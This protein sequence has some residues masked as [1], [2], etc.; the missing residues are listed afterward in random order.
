REHD[1]SRLRELREAGWRAVAAL[2]DLFGD[3]L[4]G[5]ED[6][7]LARPAVVRQVDRDPIQPGTQGAFGLEPR[8]RAVRAGERVDDDLL[9][10]R[11]IL[12]DRQTETED[13]VL[14][15]VEERVE[16]LHVAVARGV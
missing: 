16:R 13:A 9:G 8:E 11:G 14:V 1:A 7:A 15:A 10:V 5:A 12:R 4:D 3:V 6:D 2:H